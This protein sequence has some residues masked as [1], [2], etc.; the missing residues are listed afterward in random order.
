MK[1]VLREMKN[2][3]IKLAAANVKNGKQFYL[4]YFL[5]GIMSVAL[6]YIM[7]A[8]V[9]NESVKA[10]PGGDSL[11]ILLGLGVW[12]IGIFVTVF[13]LYTNSFLMKRR[14]KELGIYH[15]LGMEKKHILKIML[16]ETCGLGMGILVLGLVAGILC[17]KLIT[18]ILFLLVRFPAKIEFGLS[19]ISARNTAILFGG[20]FVITILYNSIQVVRANAMELLKGSSVGEKEPKTKVIMSIAGVISLGIGYYISLTTKNP[21]TALSLFF[22]AV[23]FVVIGTYMLFTAGSI[24]LLKL[25]RRK[26]SFYYKTGNF[27]SVSGML[28]RMKQNAAGLSNICI[29][30]TM[31]LVVLSTTIS[32]F[33]GVEDELK[34]R[35]SSDIEITAQ[36]AEVA[37]CNEVM[38]AAEEVAVYMGRTITE[39]KGFLT[40]GCLAL[41]EGTVF[42]GLDLATADTY[43]DYSEIQMLTFMNKEDGKQLFGEVPETIAQGEVVVYGY[44]KYENEVITFFGKEYKVVSSEEVRDESD[45][46][47]LSGANYYIV[48]PDNAA[49]EEI[50]RGQKEQLGGEA[51]IYTY[52]VELN[53]DG[54]SQEKVECYHGIVERMKVFTGESSERK[55]FISGSTAVSNVSYEGIYVE[56]RDANRDDFFVLYG[57]FLF[58]GIFLG[59]LFLVVTGLIIYFKQISE[60]YDDKERFIIMQK[61]G[62]SKKEVKKAIDAQVRLV[63]LLP[64][65][66]AAVHVIFAYP[67]IVKLLAILNLTNKEL[68]G[69]CLLGTILIFTGIYYAIFKCTSVIYCRIVGNGEKNN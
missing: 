44:P 55:A 12:V 25:L 56:S 45:S 19:G 61:V 30:S 36:L 48:L 13:L 8:V 31:V 40:L 62:M 41:R 21:M 59:V 1:G 43:V 18:M 54:T 51:S 66:V 57:G 10:L 60:G 9:V 15:V 5:T 47:M 28:Y 67:I 50:S 29:L 69:M 32:M 17:N 26:K 38:D 27:T 33:V 49:L 63:F 11:C 65:L 14:K 24:A 34:T 42:D 2:L 64:I 7:S 6:F 35:F 4:P 3:Y 68:Y 52:C 58:L 20:I 16:L 37:D 46:Y 22:V 53:L 39:K 23:F